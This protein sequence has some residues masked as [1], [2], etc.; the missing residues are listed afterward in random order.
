MKEDYSKA[1]RMGLRTCRRNIRQGRSPYLL[2]LESFL[3]RQKMQNPVSLGLCEI[4]VSLIAGTLTAERS[5]AFASDF[6]PIVDENS[7]F[8]Q[9]W[10][11]LYDSQ[12]EEG[13]RE[14]ILAY[15]FRNHFY[16][17]EG[18]KRI[19]VTRFVGG[20]SIHGKVYRILPERDGSEETIAY[21]EFVDFFEVTGLFEIICSKPGNYAKIANSFGQTLKDKWNDETIEDVRSLFYKFQAAFRSI[22]GEGLE[23]SE[24]DAFAIY[25]D[26]YKYDAGM[27]EADPGEMSGQV[28]SLWNEL[29]TNTAGKAIVHV[30]NPEEE[31]EPKTLLSGALAGVLGKGPAYSVK[32]PLKV[33]F[34]Y[35]KTAESSG[36]TYQHE[37]GR[38]EVQE[39]FGGA[40]E[41]YVVEECDTAERF[42]AAFAG[43]AQNGTGLVITISP[44]MMKAAQRAAVRY[45]NLKILNCSL[46]LTSSAVRTYYCRLYEV[47]Y[48]LG[49]LAASMSPD[50]RIA[51]V[52]DYPIYGTIANINAF[53]IGAGIIDP[54]VKIHLYWSTRKDR[55]YK[56]EIRTAGIRM[57]SG[58]D[59]ITPEDP[60]R[61]YGIYQIRDDGS[62]FNIAAPIQHWGVFYEK[63]IRTILNGTW[64]DRSS[65]EKEKTLNYWYGLSSGAVDVILSDDLPSYYSVKLLNMLKYSVMN[66]NVKPFSGEMHDQNGIRLEEE[67]KELT[68]DSIISMN[69]LNDNI[70]GEI[71]SA[72]EL[73]GSAQ[74]I[75]SVSGV[76]EPGTRN[77]NEVR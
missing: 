70:V 35:D 3:P 58:P 29:K 14:P 47:K 75:I 50:H 51:Y 76:N 64:G 39:K 8:A 55:D 12:Q 52:A 43:A 77:P 53:A 62:I 44:S 67:G 74:R 5:N 46:N 36:W 40:V 11:A 37:L 2:A 24:G 49:A 32:N 19:S 56:E 9:K 28:K 7:E 31:P 30:E 71:P 27:P 4:P 48:I 16:V 65:V 25:L 38:N 73:G 59:V 34:L 15:E 17:Q 6:M 63:I 54:E 69:W 18:N 66:G 23:I 68:I 57:V 22:G 72:D 41:T 45:P 26:V 20:E 1:R 10:S 60:S 13:I 21:Y 61:R 42:D 33:A